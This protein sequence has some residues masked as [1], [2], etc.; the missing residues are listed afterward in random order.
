MNK[1]RTK[2]LIFQTQ[3]HK[4]KVLNLQP[5]ISRSGEESDSTNNLEG[6][7][8]IEPNENPG[9]VSSTPRK[10]VLFIAKECSEDIASTE[11]KVSNEFVGKVSLETP[12]VDLTEKIGIEDKIDLYRAVFLDSSESED[13]TGEEN[14]ENNSEQS[15]IEEFKTIVLSEPLIPQIKPIKEGIL[16]GI[17]F[18]GFNKN[19]NESQI[20][21]KDEKFEGNLTEINPL[22]NPLLYGPRVPECI[23]ESK[24]IQNIQ[25]KVFFSSDSEDEWVEKDAVVKKTKSKHKKKDKAQ[26]HKKHTKKS[27]R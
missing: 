25:Q 18:K 3:K 22:S 11:K 5:G 8:K 9:S 14:V 7:V 27:K 19:R 24:N 1:K 2:N 16:S 10:E 17:N 20:K 23:G 21:N 13:E 12:S 6:T 26:K 4:D 15:K